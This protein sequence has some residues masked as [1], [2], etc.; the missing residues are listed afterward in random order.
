MQH[1]MR[2]DRGEIK[3]GVNYSGVC[4]RHTWL[5]TICFL[6]FTRELHSKFPFSD[7]LSCCLALLAYLLLDSL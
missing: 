3:N 2:P 4:V 6:V 7:A 5:F 1:I